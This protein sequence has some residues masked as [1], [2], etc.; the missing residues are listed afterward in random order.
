MNQNFQIIFENDDFC[1]VNKKKGLITHATLDK[2]RENL[3]DL[4]KDHYLK[5]NK[6]VFL[7]HRL[8][9]ETSGL[10]LFSLNADKNKSLQELIEEKSL[11]KIYVA[12]VNGD[13]NWAE[14]ILLKDYVKKVTVKGI[15]RQSIVFKGGDV[16][17]S[18]ARSLATSI[19]E[20]TLKTGRM[21][22]IRIQLSSRGFPIV[23]D[24]LY[25]G[26]IE[27]VKGMCLHSAYLSFSFE[28]KLYEFLSPPEFYKGYRR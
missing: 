8:D 18:M 19:V 2:S 9:K 26:S 3:F 11:Q 21:H 7:L 24:S 22:Q 16:A 14:E 28:G 23:G 25:G 20:V 15:E 12:K 10:I 6:E 1:V 13:P 17:L 27:K 5:V 4:L